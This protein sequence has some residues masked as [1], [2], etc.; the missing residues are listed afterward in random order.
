MCFSL[1]F[2][3]IENSVFQT[4][5]Q[6]WK[7]WKKKRNSYFKD[8]LTLLSNKETTVVLECPNFFTVI[9]QETTLTG[10]FLD[11]WQWK[12][13][14]IILNTFLIFLNAFLWYC[15]TFFTFLEKLFQ[16]HWSRNDPVR[17]VSWSMVVKSWT[18]SKTVLI[19][20]TEIAF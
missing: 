10:S 14:F 6:H 9:D 16:C 5:S 4:G 19:Y 13:F 17:V 8:W 2:H 7:I 11:Q 1:L 3:T 20:R 12:S 18:F 15:W